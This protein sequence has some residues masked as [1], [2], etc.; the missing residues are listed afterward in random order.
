MKVMARLFATGA[1]MAFA[2]LGS[3][4]NA[5]PITSSSNNPYN[6]TWNQE[7]TI[8]G[9]LT[10]SGS[11]VVSGFG[12]DT[13]PS[14]ELSLEITLINTAASNGSERLTAFAFGI[15]PNATSASIEIVD[16]T[17]MTKVVL[18]D[19]VPGR[20]AMEANV[21]GVEICAFDGPNCSGGGSGGLLS[22]QTQIFKLLLAGTWTDSV[23]IDPI[24]IRYQTS[25][26]SFTFPA[27]NG[28]GEPPIP[29]E[30][31]PEPASLGLLGLGLVALA[32]V[33][34]RRRSLNAHS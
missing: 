6:F 26:G 25:Y 12:T 13:A 4:S 14:S 21:Q 22:G 9:P 29:P 31:I 17:G 18:L 1:I 27:A 3:T 23:T 33:T 28:N 32:A 8:E 24:G 10:G 16:G 30:A 7:T 2:A 34:R 19:E 11:F 5:A 20:G 15:D